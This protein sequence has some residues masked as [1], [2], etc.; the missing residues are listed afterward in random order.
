MESTGEFNE[1]ANQKLKAFWDEFSVFYSEALESSTIQATVV[2]YSMTRAKAGKRI[3]EVAIGSGHACRSFATNFMQPG[4]VYYGSDISSGMIECAVTNFN[5]SDLAECSKIKFTALEQSDSI[6]LEE[7]DDLMK[8]MFVTVA[9]NEKLPYADGVFDTYIS[10]LSLMIVDQHKNQ[11][12]E[13]FRVMQ[14]GATAG[15]TVWGREE[16][17]KHL[18]LMPKALKTV[19]I[20]LVKPPRTFFHLNNTENLEKDIR[21]VGFVNIK[22]YHSPMNLAMTNQELYELNSRMPQFANYLKDMDEDKK[23]AVKAEFSKLYDETF[24]EDT[25]IPPQFEVI[26]VLASKP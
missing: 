7:G 18:T 23:E 16:Y 24:G 22:I 14:S 10:N 25:L 1:E 11:L 13:A 20:E 4:A 9:N 6:T 3:C 5:N 26:V 12:K 17:C 21:E 15:F 19:D 2:L 8:K